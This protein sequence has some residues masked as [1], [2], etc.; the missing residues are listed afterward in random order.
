MPDFTPNVPSACSQLVRRVVASNAGAMTGP[1]TNT[2]LVGIDE[3]AVVDPGPDEAEHID[4]LVRAAGP[5]RIRWIV[6]THMHHDH[7]GGAQRLAERTGAVIYAPTLS[8][9]SVPAT[10]LL[11][12]ATEIEGSEFVLRAHRTPGHTLHHVCVLLEEER[13]LFTGDTVLE[14]M[15]TVITPDDGDMAQ[16]L[17][18]LQDIASWRL[19]TIYPGHGAAIDD[20]ATYVRELIDH[21]IT[22]EQEIIAVIAGGT[23][24]IGDIVARVYPELAAPLRPVAEWQVYAHL[25]KLRNDGRVRG[26]DQRSIWV[27]AD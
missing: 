20:P 15:T 22:R 23:G 5:D 8:D 24:R 6:L 21:R 1:G 26:R 19:R 2:Y 25:R 9:H 3:V 10:V 4:A 7:A 13:A 16:Y 17:G 18:S 11:E 14:G 27:L 12:D